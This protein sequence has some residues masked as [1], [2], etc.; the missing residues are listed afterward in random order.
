MS[1]ISQPTATPKAPG[2]VSDPLL[3][4]LR[5]LTE[6]FG[7]PVASETL[8]AG[9]P[10]EAELFTPELFVRAAARQGIASTVVRKRLSRVSR[11]LLPA[12]L[13]LDNGEAC[14][15]VK[16]G[17]RDAQVL[18][19]DDPGT[20]R[21]VKLGELAGDYTGYCIFAHPEPEADGRMGDTPAAVDPRNWFWGTLWRFRGYYLE[22]LIA[23]ALVNILALA[24]ALYVMNVYDR[25]VPN[26]ATETLVVLAVGT[27]LAVGFEFLARTIRSYFLD[28]AARKADVL[29]ASKLFQQ[30]MSLRMEARPG[31]SGAFASQLRE[32]ESLRDFCASATLA[33][34]SDVP[35]V[36]FFI[37]VISL[38]G[39]PLWLVPGLAVPAV[40]LV[41][42]LAQWPL[43]VTMRKHMRE[44]NLKHG[45][46]VE[47]VENSEELKTLSAE[48]RL[49]RRFEDYTAL[50]GAS[51]SRSRLISSTM[52][53]FT[54][55]VQ[56]A[57]TI[58]VVLWG[59]FLIGDGE[60]TVGALIA[61]VIISGRGL[62]PLGQL[63]GLMVRYQQARTAY[64]MLNDLMKKPVERPVGRRFVHRGTIRPRF[65]FSKVDFSY[66]GQEGEAITDLSCVIPQGEHV[67]ILGRVGSGKST[68][69]RLA[70]GLYRP[71]SGA[72]MLDGVDIQQLDPAIIR[73]HVGLIGQSP[74]LFYG[75]LRDNLTLGAPW[76]ADEALLSILD[77]VG[78][79]PLVSRHP[80]GLDLPIGERG[81]GLSGGQRQSVSIAR[82]LA[83]APQGLLMDEPT[84][85]MDHNTEAHFL[86]GMKRFLAG[87]TLLV[88]THKPS[89]LALVDRLLVVDAGKL[90]MDGPRDRVLSELGASEGDQAQGQRSPGSGAP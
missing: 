67:G 27:A 10:L 47:S 17:R 34:L 77:V 55:L 53:N 6:L 75:T 31:S 64:L 36:V 68:L 90:V 66:P 28:S 3:D 19:P 89:V 45:L 22:A 41:G 40:V 7:R 26:N 18:F 87:R 72:V 74:N 80:L 35:F 20:P 78:L 83:M 73:R 61:C 56:Q 85:A 16:K 60:L 71:L 30:A 79:L 59:V 82:S 46:L 25:V 38:I 62:A 58:S 15:L 37:W 54:M 43:A 51:A 48:G 44:S 84:S 14:V 29:L 4:S 81:M 21:K 9:L 8:A 2:R 52:V 11:L 12:V 70:L 65:E 69:L 42:L 5:I 49:L 1:A 23:A 24:T 57:I 88:A 63:A 33:A 76:V 39:G 13:L 32:F 86:D 50:T